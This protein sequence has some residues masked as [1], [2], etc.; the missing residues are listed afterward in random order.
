MDMPQDDPARRAKDG[1]G[2]HRER[3]LPNPTRDH[4][5]WPAFR[6]WADEHLGDVML[7]LYWECWLAALASAERP[8]SV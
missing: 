1:V 3:G 4:P 7:S 8:A 6:R 5:A 2:P